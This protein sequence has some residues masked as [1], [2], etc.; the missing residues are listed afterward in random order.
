VECTKECSGREKYSRFNKKYYFYF[1]YRYLK[2]IIISGLEIL[3]DEAIDTGKLLFDALMKQKNLKDVLIDKSS[4]MVDNIAGTIIKKINE[5]KQEGGGSSLS[6]DSDEDSDVTNEKFFDKMKKIK[7]PQS[8]SSCARAT[9]KRK[10]KTSDGKI[11][12][13]KLKIARKKICEDI[14]GE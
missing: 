9:I 7:K 3:K 2:P 4:D 13:K 10:R 5:H 11:N 12:L 14:F 6:I 1:S 8:T